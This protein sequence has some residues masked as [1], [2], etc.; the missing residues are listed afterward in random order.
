[1]WDTFSENHAIRRPRVSGSVAYSRVNTPAAWH[2]HNHLSRRARPSAPLGINHATLDMVDEWP[3]SFLEV[4]QQLEKPQAARHI[5]DPDENDRK[6]ANDQSED[7]NKIDNTQEGESSAVALGTRSGSEPD[8]S[9]S[10]NDIDSSGARP[11]Y[12]IEN[13]LK[14]Q[15]ALTMACVVNRRADGRQTGGQTD[16]R[17]YLPTAGVSSR[18]MGQHAVFFPISFQSCSFLV[19]PKKSLCP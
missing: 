13:L 5:E 1:M 17:S 3:V 15:T 6:S 4:H 7:R 9:A 12:K 10:A 16:E 14:R 19:G 11:P 8:D 18:Q 2:H